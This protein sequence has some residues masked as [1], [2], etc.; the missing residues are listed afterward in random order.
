M[1]RILILLLCLVVESTGVHAME[2][3]SDTLRNQRGVALGGATVTVFLAGTNIKA[4][5]FDDNGSTPK[6]NPFLT[7]AFTGQYHFYAMNGVYD[8][9]YRYQ[10]TTFDPNQTKRIS[11]VD[12]NDITF[13]SGGGG[14]G[15]GGGGTT[16]S[17]TWTVVAVSTNSTMTGTHAVYVCDATAGAVT[18]TMPLASAA[19][20]NDFMV[21]KIDSTSNACIVQRAG[22]DLIDTLTSIPITVQSQTVG[23]YARAANIWDL[24]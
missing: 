17:A 2:N 22:S 24:F 1:T 6:A 19:I 23:F 3:Y 5:L 8:L 4:T 10:N 7:D 13:P 9:V 14:G 11:L 15:G 12:V 21:K 16:V 20:G 18:L